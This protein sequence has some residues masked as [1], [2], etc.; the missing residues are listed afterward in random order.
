MD[1]VGGACCTVAVRVAVGAAS[2]FA[3]ASAAVAAAAGPGG[4][5]RGGGAGLPV[6]FLVGDAR[7]VACAATAAAEFLA[8]RAAGAAADTRPVGAVVAGHAGRA[9]AVAAARGA[10]RGHALARVAASGSFAA[11]ARALAVGRAG[12][13]GAF[14]G[15]FAVLRSIL[16]RCS[17]CF[18]PHLTVRLACHIDE[19]LASRIRSALSL[20]SLF[21]ISCVVSFAVG[22]PDVSR[23]VNGRVHSAR[24]CVC[25][26]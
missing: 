7:G 9:A 15:F 4:A 20:A 1:V 6:H 10:A 3:F 18:G 5:F 17:G 21:R 19:A 12:L 22:Q 11:V 16:F 24:V 8:A 23:A 26:S 13:P 14:L 25:G 2:A